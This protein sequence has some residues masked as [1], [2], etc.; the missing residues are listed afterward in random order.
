M[1]KLLLAADASLLVEMLVRH[2]RQCVWDA[3]TPASYSNPSYSR[4]CDTHNQFM[5]ILCSQ[6]VAEEIEPMYAYLLTYTMLALHSML[7]YSCCWCSRRAERTVLQ[8]M[9]VISGPF[10][11]PFSYTSQRHLVHLIAFIKHLALTVLGCKL[12]TSV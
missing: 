9:R 5:H 3:G 11:L 1:I 4:C 12:E 2:N 10:L 7:Q 8:C 6:Q